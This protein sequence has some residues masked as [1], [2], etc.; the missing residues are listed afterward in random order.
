MALRVL[1]EGKKCGEE[2]VP[3]RFCNTVIRILLFHST[4]IYWLPIVCQENKKFIFL[5]LKV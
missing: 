5:E 1:V 4:N 2:R 3:L